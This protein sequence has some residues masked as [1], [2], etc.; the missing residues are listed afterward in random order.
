MHTF[1]E[2]PKATQQTTSGK[3]TVPARGHFWQSPEVSPNPYSQRTIGNQVVQRMLKANMEEDKGDSIT[4][5]SARFG[6]D[7][8][9]IPVMPPDRAASNAASESNRGIRSTVEHHRHTFSAAIRR[10]GAVFQ[11][12]S[13]SGNEHVAARNFEA[14]PTRASIVASER[15]TPQ[16]R[17]GETFRFSALPA[18]EVPAQWDAIRATLTYE[19]TINPIRPPAILTKFGQTDTRIEANRSS[20]RPENGTFLVEL[21][22]DNV[23]TFWVAG[24]TR[25]NIASDADPN[26]TQ[27]NYPTVVS[28]LTPSPRAVHTGGL[29]L[30]KNQPPRSQFWA[31]DLTIIHERF[32]ADENEKFGREG[33]I[34]ARD[35]LEGQ[36]AQNLNEVQA[37]VGRVAPMVAQRINAA[38]TPPG[39]E[40]RAYDHGAADYTAR[41]RAIKTKGDARGY[42]SRPTPP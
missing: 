27:T 19:P 21:V 25:K 15:S 28:D 11:N 33:A 13:M 20:G 30:L 37:L 22:I 4:T 34:A 41:A 8:S 7:F 40:Q 42:V 32:H 12:D 3:S 10:V 17:E 9:K 23:I 6:H 2:K 26:I 14:S 35:W 31:E 36:T 5:E 38:M 16:A 1:A 18:I 24:G 39:V 29:D